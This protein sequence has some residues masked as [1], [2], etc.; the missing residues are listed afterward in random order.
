[1]KGIFENSQRICH[2]GKKYER[3]WKLAHVGRNTTWYRL[4]DTAEPVIQVQV[5]I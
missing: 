3:K 4:V 5:L 2:Y 1:M